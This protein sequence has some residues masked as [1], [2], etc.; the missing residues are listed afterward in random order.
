MIEIDDYFYG[1]DGRYHFDRRKIQAA[2]A[3]SHDRLRRA[4]IE[5]RPALAVANTHVTKKEYQPY[6]RRAEEYGYQVIE[7]IVRSGFTNVHDVPEER[8]SDMKQRFEF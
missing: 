3:E 5:E 6:I 8:I 4:M 7:L 1:S 2:V